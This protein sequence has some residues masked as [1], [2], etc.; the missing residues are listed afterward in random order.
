MKKL[1]SITLALILALS[2]SVPA[3]AEVTVDGDP[4]GTGEVTV[5][6]DADYVIANAS[7]DDLTVNGKVAGDD[8]ARD[9]VFATSSAKVTV[10]ESVTK[11]GD[12]SDFAVRANTGDV[13]VKKDVTESGDGDAIYTSNNGNVVVGGDVSES[14]NGSAIQAYF[15]STVEV[16]GSVTESGAGDAISAFSGASITVEGNV[17]ESGKGFAV[18]A[19]GAET[20]VT[21]NGNV[22]ESGT[23]SALQA[24]EATIIVIGNVE[25]KNAGDAI[26]AAKNATVIV[27]GNV[28]DGVETAGASNAVTSGFGATVIVEGLVTG[29]LNTNGQT[30]SGTIYIGKLNGDIKED[31]DL[32]KIHYLIGVASEGSA[33]LSAVTLVSDI[34]A[35]GTIDGINEEGYRYTTTADTTALKGETIVLKPADGKILTVSGFNGADVTY[36]ANEDGTVTFTLGDSFTGGLQNLVLVLANKPSP[37]SEPVYYIV[38]L[39]SVTEVEFTAPEGVEEGLIKALE[40]ADHVGITVDSS[41]V[42]D[43]S[44]KVLKDGEELSAKD[45]SIYTHADG[46]IDVILSNTYLFALGSGSYDFTAVVNG[47]EIPFTV[48]VAK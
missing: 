20:I 4:K 22:D 16:T 29:Q 45:F 36:V 1:L 6:G 37:D 46:S 28:T 25:E 40:S 2:L 33:A 21:V 27:G 12:S 32:S 15:G 42:G 30:N 14:D 3:F 10:S 8:S 7:G 13:T 24:V 31:A 34:V 5:D 23:G 19:S 41:L 39:D 17:T 38:P 26:S 43:G 44:V 18:N 9:S 47:L 35:Q 11:T 48:A